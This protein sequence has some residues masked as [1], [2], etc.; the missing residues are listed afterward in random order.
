M[1]LVNIRVV[2]LVQGIGFRWLARKA[3]YRYGIK[4][5]VVNNDDGSVS[6]EAEGT[7][8]QIKQFIDWCKNGSTS[9]R[10]DQIEVHEGKMKFHTEFSIKA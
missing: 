6:I 2:G 4:G 9:G 3:A 1:K 8:E 10:V 5:Y 7:D